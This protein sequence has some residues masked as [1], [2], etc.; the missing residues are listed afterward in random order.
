[1]HM[2]VEVSHSISPTKLKEKHTWQTDAGHTEFRSR[3]SQVILWKS[4]QRF[5]LRFPPAIHYIT[6]S[7]YLT[8]IFC[9]DLDSSQSPLNPMPSSSQLT[10]WPRL[11]NSL[12]RSTAWDRGDKPHQRF[13]NHNFNY[14]LCQ[15]QVFCEY[16]Y[17][18][19]R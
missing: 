10:A 3:S 1:M 17:N 4:K 8:S 12:P 15:Q 11:I 9:S 14:N 13:K 7:I 2:K 19:R 18:F 5:L 6:Q 16:Y